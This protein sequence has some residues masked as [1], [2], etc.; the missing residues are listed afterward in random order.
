MHFRFSI[1]AR[2]FPRAPRRATPAPAGIARRAAPTQSGSPRSKIQRGSILLIVMVTLLFAAF[3]LVVFVEKAGVDLLVETRDASARR[4]RREAFSALEVTLAT[5]EDFRAANSGLHSAAEGWGDPLVWAGWSPTEGR[6]VEISFE[7]ESGKISLAHADD[8]AF[9]NLFKSWEISQS[10]AE[11]LTDALLVWMKKDHIPKSAFPAD[12]ERGEL[13]YVPPLRPLKSFAELA[14]IDQ[15]RDFFYDERGR[16]NERWFRF[17]AAFSTF[18][19]A[20]TNLNSAQGDVLAALGNYD[21][22]Q[23]SRFGEY[24]TGTGA[25]QTQGPGFFHT[26][27]E[28]ATLLGTP[29]LPNSFDTQIQAL[30]INLTVREGRLFYR[31]SAVVAPP[32]GATIVTT[33]ATSQRAQ[34]SGAQRTAAPTAAP[35]APASGTTAANNAASANQKKLNYPFTLLEIRENDAIPS[36]PPPPSKPA[37]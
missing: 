11:R 6:T 27:A 8:T 12:Y 23:R 22:V 34:P 18:N 4:L 29:R 33:T 17:T 28:A 5:L 7:D 32:N 26:T 30:R 20:K 31:L 10:D 15:A 3:A 13:P 24:L 9:A 37:L 21:P 2:L 36:A 25:Y 16:P 19:F 35:T 14:A 1:S